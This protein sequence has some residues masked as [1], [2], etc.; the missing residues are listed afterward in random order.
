MK[1]MICFAS[2]LCEHALDVLEPL[3]QRSL[4]RKQHAVGLTEL[5]DLL[6][7]ETFPL[8]PDNVEPD[9]VRAIADGHAERDDVGGDA[10]HAT[11]KR[12]GADAHELVDR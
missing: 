11:D 10:G 1:S 9:E 3:F 6:A 7:R 5:V 4:A 12:V 8:Q 2:G